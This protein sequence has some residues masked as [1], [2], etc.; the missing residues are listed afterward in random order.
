MRTLN[1]LNRRKSTASAAKYILTD[2]LHR[3]RCVCV[4][5]DEL[6]TTVAHWLA[7]LGVHS[8]IAADFARTV[9]DGNWAVAHALADALS[10]DV[11]VAA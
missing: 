5:A 9:C 2:R 11:A 4:S 8:G 3:E 10:I 7:Q 6:D 1:P